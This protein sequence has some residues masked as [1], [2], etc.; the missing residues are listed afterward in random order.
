MNEKLIKVAIF[1]Y[2]DKNDLGDFI[3]E[4][5]TDLN[6]EDLKKYCE[7]SFTDYKYFSFSFDDKQKPNFVKT[8]NI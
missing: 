5:V 6:E 8:I 4:I 7:K 2:K 3:K 1:G